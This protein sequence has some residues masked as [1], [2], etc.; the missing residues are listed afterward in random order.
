MS[1]ADAAGGQPLPQ[2][3]LRKYIAYARAH[4][5]PA[6]SDAAKEA[7]QAFYLQLRADSAAPMGGGGA[8]GAPITA[9]QLESLVRAPAP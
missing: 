8:G 3:L 4:V 1:G 6:L 2:Q 5:Q 9:R 7:L